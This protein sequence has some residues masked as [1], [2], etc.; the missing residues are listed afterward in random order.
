MKSISVDNGI[1]APPGG[2]PDWP[3]EMGVTTCACSIM[4][5]FMLMIQKNSSKIDD[6]Y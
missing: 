1:E 2:G 5:L 3:P 6:N 4:R